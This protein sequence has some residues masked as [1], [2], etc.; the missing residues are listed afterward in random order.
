MVELNLLLQIQLF[1]G[2]FHGQA[3][4]VYTVARNHKYQQTDRKN[5][6]QSSIKT[7]PLWVTLYHFQNNLN[8]ERIRYIK[9]HSL[10]ITL[11]FTSIVPVVTIFIPCYLPANFC[12]VS[13]KFQI[14]E[15][16]CECTNF[17]INLDYLLLKL[18]TQSKQFHFPFYKIFSI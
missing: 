5:F 2:L 17:A 16:Y 10:Q 12:K 7:H 15:S 9:S 11:Y 14:A 8:Q 4:K 3:K 1:C 13:A 18:V 6:L